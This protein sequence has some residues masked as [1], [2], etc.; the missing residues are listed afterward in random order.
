M[1]FQMAAIQNQ[2]FWTGE[3]GEKGEGKDSAQRPQESELSNFKAMHFSDWF[4]S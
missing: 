1:W 4:I 2:S 3:C